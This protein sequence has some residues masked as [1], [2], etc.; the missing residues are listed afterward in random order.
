VHISRSV[1]LTPPKYIMSTTVLASSISPI[2]GV[3]PVETYALTLLSFDSAHQVRDEVL[4]SLEKK[5]FI[6]R[7]VHKG[8]KSLPSLTE[9]ARTLLATFHR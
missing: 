8:V 7:L 9:K 6:V 3:T 1:G 5:K 2:V 4:E